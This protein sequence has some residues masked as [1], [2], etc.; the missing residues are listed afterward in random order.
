MI[1][2]LSN[3][4]IPTVTPSMAQT[5]RMQLPVDPGSF[6]YSHFRYVSGTP[7]PE[8]TTGISI[9]KLN[10]LDVL[11]GQLNQIRRHDRPLPSAAPGP[12]GAIDALVEQYRN[13]I[14]EVRSAAEAMPYIHTPSAPSGALFSLSS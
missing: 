4:T 12:D 5:A 14:L 7:A 13:Q 6:I 9:N 1:R 2:G 10:L 11:I 3:I 8:G